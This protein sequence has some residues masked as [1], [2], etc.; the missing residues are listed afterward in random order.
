MDEVQA[1]QLEITKTK[2]SNLHKLISKT[3][4]KVA[5]GIALTAVVSV[6]TTMLVGD[7][8]AQI[9]GNAFFMGWLLSFVLLI[10][11][12]VRVRT[13]VKHREN[14]KA[15]A[16]FYVIAAIFGL[17]LTLPFTYYTLDSIGAAFLISGAI[18]LGLAR[19]GT[20]TN[21]DFV[22][23]GRVLFVMLLG[24]VVMTFIGMFIGMGTGGIIMNILVMLLFSAYIVYDSNQLVR[25][26]QNVAA[27]DIE[28]ISTLM[29]VDLYLDFINL[30]QRVL[31]LVGDRR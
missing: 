1:R 15:Q 30:F 25:R 16:A 2:R 10:A 4:Q 13:F 24:T 17:V 6:G 5:A 3:Y 21:K 29:A 14:T 7:Q 20:T 19:F 27:A 11:A 22:S 28:G 8:L 9:S 31:A 26:N 18:F 12:A 23:W